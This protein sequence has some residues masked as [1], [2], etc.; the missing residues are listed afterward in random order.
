MLTNHRRQNRHIMT[1]IAVQRRTDNVAPASVADRRRSRS[2]R[3]A[4]PPAGSF[5]GGFRTPAPGVCR[6]AV[7]GRHPKPLYEREV[8]K[9]LPHGLRSQVILLFEPCCRAHP[10]VPTRSISTPSRAGPVKG[11]P[12]HCPC[13]ARLISRPLLDR[14]EHDGRLRRVGIA[15]AARRA[16]LPS[17]NRAHVAIRRAPDRYRTPLSI[18]RAST[19]VKRVQ[20]VQRRCPWARAT[21]A[22][23]YIRQLR[24]GLPLCCMHGQSREKDGLIF[25][26]ADWRGQ[27]CDGFR[28]PRIRPAQ[29]STQRSVG[30]VSR[31]SCV[32][33]RWWVEDRALWHHAVLDVTPK[34]NREL[35]RN[36][37]DQDLPHP[38]ALTCSALNEPSG[39]CTLR[40]MPYPQPCGLNHNGPHVATGSAPPRRYC[41]GL[42]QGPE[43]F[44]PAAGW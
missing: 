24:Y 30:T 8:V 32:P 16:S 9:A 37:D 33:R 44:P 34:G 28:Q 38:R 27:I 43:S 2:R 11:W 14:S 22:S 40:L 3:C 31:S 39:E 4:V 42:G 5:L 18:S 12:S 10:V 19:H 21:I 7:A 25:T 13:H 23:P 29:R 41:R 26:T 20:Q 15:L 35:A 36:G 1:T 17:R 6:S